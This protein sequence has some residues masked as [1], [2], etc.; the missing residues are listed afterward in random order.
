L[1][2]IEQEQDGTQAVQQEQLQN[3][4]ERFVTSGVLCEDYLA[5]KMC[6]VTEEM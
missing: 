6:E 5:H 4:R 3:Q 1:F 2:L